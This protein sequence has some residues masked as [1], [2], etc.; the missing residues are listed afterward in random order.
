MDLNLGRLRNLVSDPRAA[1]GRAVEVAGKYIN[2]PGVR[3]AGYGLAGAGASVLGNAITGQLDQKPS[4][5][6][7]AEAIGA[8]ALGAGAGYLAGNLQRK[9][10]PH[11]REY[12]DSLNAINQERV[13]MAKD[14]V[15]NGATDPATQQTFQQLGDQARMMNAAIYTARALPPAVSFAAAGL[16]GAVAGGLANLAGVPQTVDPEQYQ[17]SNSPAAM[18][19]YARSMAQMN[20]PLYY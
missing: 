5:R 8:G 18:D 12:E 6:I 19:F 13:R 4:E 3:T 14:A 15:S 20:T 11:V 17:S 9:M 16:G 10:Q 2:S 7:V 1:M